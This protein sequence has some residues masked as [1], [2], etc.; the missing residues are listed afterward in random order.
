METVHKRVIKDIRDGS[1]NLRDEFGVYIAPEENDFYKVHFI[2]PGPEDTPFDGGLYHG[3]IRLNNEHPYKAPNIHMITPNG[4]FMAEEYP[5]PSGSRGICTTASAFHPSDWTPM[6]NLETV[7][8]GFISLMCD[9]YDG[10]VGGINSTPT[11]TKK[12]AKNSINHIKSE[13]IIRELFPELYLGLVEGTYKKVKLA[14][15]GKKKP[16]KKNIVDDDSDSDDNIPN[17]RS[18]K[19]SK[20]S[21]K[22][23]KK[24]ADTSDEESA[25]YSEPLGEDEHSNSNKKKKSSKK[26]KEKIVI[27]SDSEDSE[28]E[29][30]DEIAQTKK[31]RNTKR[32]TSRK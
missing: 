25:I 21:V 4:R 18:I 29:D 8:K 32:K 31:S 13:A 6:N 27:L 14:E 23:T 20:K 22:R 24:R 10:G 30:S 7:I 16:I 5:I 3:M 19:K 28:E 15:L 17:K 9:P 2:L 26:K 1:K 12:L 11:E